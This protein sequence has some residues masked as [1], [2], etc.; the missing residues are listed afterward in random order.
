MT[1][2]LLLAAAVAAALAGA[3]IL[4]R[5]RSP[6]R[7]AEPDWREVEY[8]VGEF[9]AARDTFT[10]GCCYWFA[11]ILCERFGG[12]VVLD[13]LDNHFVAELGD[14]YYDVTGDVTE[15]IR[16]AEVVLSMDELESYDAL[17]SRRIWRDC[18]LKTPPE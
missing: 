17:W 4:S 5:R 10:S 6:R 7:P 14:R 16:A 9:W 12:R 3:A 13:V 18:V 1:S 11:W 15:R 8:F 2:G